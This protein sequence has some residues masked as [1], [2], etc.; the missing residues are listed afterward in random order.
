MACRR[1]G[2]QIPSAP[3]QVTGHIKPPGHPVPPPQAADRQ[4]PGVLDHTRA[5]NLSLRTSRDD[6]A[7]H[8]STHAAGPKESAFNCPQCSAYATMTWAQKMGASP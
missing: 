2:V 8:D 5:E 3:P 6:G 7:S 1:P 4:H